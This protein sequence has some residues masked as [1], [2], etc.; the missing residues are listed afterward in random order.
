MTCPMEIFYI[1]FGSAYRTTEFHY[2]GL[3][4]RVRSIRHPA[5]PDLVDG[6]GWVRVVASSRKRAAYLAKFY[7]RNEYCGIYDD[8]SMWDRM[9]E[10]GYYESNPG[11]LIDS[12]GSLEL[13]V[14]DDDG[15]RWN[16]R[17]HSKAEV[18]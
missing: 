16:A 7:L 3:G 18:A 1:S 13:A 5:F 6:R 14:I 4:M 2:D 10:G 12:L 17:I 15:I 11:R 8:T 9:M